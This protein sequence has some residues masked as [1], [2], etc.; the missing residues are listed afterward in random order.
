M[1]FSCYL[2]VR[3][4]VFHINFFCLF[5]INYFHYT[6]YDTNNSSILRWGGGEA[7]LLAC[8]P[9]NNNAILLLWSSHTQHVLKKHLIV[10]M[11]AGLHGIK[12]IP[13][14]MFLQNNDVKIMT[15][16]IRV[17]L[18]VQRIVVNEGKSTTCSIL[19]A[20]SSHAHVSLKMQLNIAK[21]NILF[22]TSTH[23][24]MHVPFRM[25]YCIALET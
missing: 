14:C 4:A 7:W 23:A 22:L 2:P 24:S 20:V 8:C 21:Q 13:L 12:V 15:K 17:F 10:A 18:N 1:F 19:I 9:W 6:S 11:I 16:S 25:F 5:T 3:N